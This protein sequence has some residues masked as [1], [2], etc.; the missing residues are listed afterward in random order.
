MSPARIPSL[1]DTNSR[2]RIRCLGLSLMAMIGLALF[3]VD[4]GAACSSFQPPPELYVGDMASDAACTQNDIQ[5]AIDAATCIYGTNIIITREH[6]YTAQ[7]LTINGKHV[8]LIARGNGDLCGPVS[9]PICAPV[10][11]PPPT[12]PLGTLSGSGH[13]GDAVLTIGGTSNVSLKYFDISGGQQASGFSGGGIQFVGS[14]SLTLDTSWVRGNHAT[15]GGGIYF[16][17][18]GATTATLSVLANTQILSNTADG[19]GGGILIQGN[20]VLNV[21]QP[22]TLIQYNHA[23]GGYGGGIAVIGPAHANIGSPGVFGTGAAIGVV[24]N[25]TAAYGGGIAVVAGSNDNEYALV[26]LFTTDASRPVQINSNTASQTGGGIYLKPY[27][28]AIALIRNVPRLCA[29]DFRIADNIAQE[30]AAIYGDVDSGVSSV[31]SLVELGSCY[32]SGVFPASLGAVPCANSALCNT[33]DEN[34][35][36]DPTLGSAI[37][38]QDEGLLFANRFAMRNNN[39]AH[40]IRI[41][42]DNTP[43][44]LSDCLLA[45]NT[46]AHELIYLTGNNTPLRIEACT[47]ANN[48]IGAAHVIHTESDL[49]INDSIIAEPGT[50]ALDYSGNPANLVVYYVVSNDV[51]T[52]PVATGVIQGTPTFVDLAGGDYHLQPGQLLGV[53]LAPVPS[54]FDLTQG[55]D[56]DGK[57]RNIDLPTVINAYGPRDIGAYEMQNLFRECGTADSIFC[58]GFGP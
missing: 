44:Q 5:S 3:A 20:A 58:D 6:T 53:D 22:Q 41:V 40:A 11:A 9:P 16:N 18:T 21:L 8:N 12:S 38:M 31:G 1:T 19:S 50:L 37:L 42:G 57:S 28:N 54:G 13:S 24:S 51:T 33:I 4:A 45:N 32:E 30:G 49:S 48:L 35:A 39:V 7:H 36:T 17:G 10:C 25:N 43:A 27:R 34:A 47:F 14:G 23:P 26:Q 55:V 56:L 15:S 52:L 46:S 2:F 29:W